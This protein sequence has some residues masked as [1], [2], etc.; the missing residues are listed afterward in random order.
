[1]EDWLSTIPRFTRTW[2][3]GTIALSL[4]G[5]FQLINVYWLVLDADRLFNGFQLWRPVTALLYYPTSMHFLFNLY[6]LYNYSLRLE[7]GMFAQRPAD[8]LFMLLFSWTCSVIVAL[9][10]GFPLLM[11]VMVL[12]VIYVWCQLN[13]D[14]IVTFWF[15]LQFKA[16]YLPWVILIF[17]VVIVHSGLMEL[18]GILIGHLYFFLMFKYPEDFGGRKLLQT[19]Q[20]L[21]Y[22]FPTVGGAARFGNAPVAPRDG[23]G[24][25]TRGAFRG[26]GHT[27]G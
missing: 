4:L 26:Q 17:N 24:V 11:D 12:V 5:R 16:M 7:T 21:Y 3:V 13:K 27:L 18:V 20:F 14:T 10:A 23:G 25:G 22:Y 8:Y 15:G 2:F 6:F 19:P 1:M 9:L